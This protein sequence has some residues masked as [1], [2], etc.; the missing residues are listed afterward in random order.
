MTVDE[1]KT[2]NCTVITINGRLDT[3]TYSMLESRLIPLIDQGNHRI[4]VDCS[5]ME[6]VSSTGLRVLLV[7]LKKITAANGKM[8][9]CSLR[10]NIREIFDISGFSQIFKVATGRSEGLKLLE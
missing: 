1:E 6:Y 2:G 10:E 3:V 7:G 8:V 9:I 4:L 5:G